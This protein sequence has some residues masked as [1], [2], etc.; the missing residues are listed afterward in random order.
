[1]FEPEWLGPLLSSRQKWRKVKR[2]DVSATLKTHIMQIL[3]GWTGIGCLKRGINCS[4]YIT[5]D[6]THRN[7]EQAVVALPRYNPILTTAGNFLLLP[8]ISDC[9]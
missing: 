6:D 9:L 3:N 5:S 8:L 4:G 2:N 1:M 7:E